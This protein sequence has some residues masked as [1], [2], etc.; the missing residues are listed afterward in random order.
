MN[1]QSMPDGEAAA[2]K[3]PGVKEKQLAVDAP[4]RTSL[5]DG[6]TL[7]VWCSEECGRRH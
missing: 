1:G 6:F 2:R 3:T 5:A 7:A 4:T